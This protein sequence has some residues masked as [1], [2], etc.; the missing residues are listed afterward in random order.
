MNT[1]ERLQQYLQEHRAEM[2]RDLIRLARIPSVQA[3]P[4]EHAPFG[5]ECARCLQEAAKLFREN[6]F[7]VREYPDSGYALAELG[8]GEKSVGLFAHLDVVPV[9]AEDWLLTAPFETIE[10]DGFLIGRGV[11]D[12]KN[13]AIAALYLLKAVRELNLPL[14]NRLV[15]YLGSNEESGMK[16]IQRYAA[17]QQAPTVSLVPD[18]GFPFSLGERGILRLDVKSEQ[19]MTDVL[20]LNGGEAYNTV[21]PGLVCRLRKSEALKAWLEAHARAWLSVTEEADALCLDVRGVA[22]HA[23]YPKGGESAFYRL[24]SLLAECEELCAADLEALRAAAFALSDTDGTA[25]GIANSDPVLGE[26][27]SA[28]GIVRLEDGRLMFTLDIRHGESVTGAE[29]MG[30]LEETLAPRGLHVQVHSDS[31]AFTIDANDPLTVA[32]EAAYRAASGDQTGKPYYMSGGTYCKYIPRAYATGTC[33]GGDASV[34]NLPKGHGGAHSAD[35]CLSVDGWL[36]GCR[37]LSSMALAL[38]KQI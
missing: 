20:S 15:V 12:N 31:R 25:L 26:L 5:E 6:G 37:I 10:K 9:N 19:A 23:G 35:E 38:D 11:D 36:E 1:Q 32:V 7:V 13:G 29:L 18:S 4:A 3:A 34:L 22:A 24:S 27:T 33:R 2:V 28:N 17:E 14:Q 21:M 16:D 30:R 8:E